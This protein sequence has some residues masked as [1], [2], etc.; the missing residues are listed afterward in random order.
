MLVPLLN[1]YGRPFIG[2]IASC[3]YLLLTLNEKFLYYILC[4]YVLILG[5]H[6]N[7]MF[8]TPL[9]YT[10]VCFWFFSPDDEMTGHSSLVLHVDSSHLQGIYICLCVCACVRACVHVCMHVCTE[11]CMCVYM[12]VYM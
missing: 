6:T 11:V 3:K 7:V 10:V 5:C 8:P 4:T 9:Y 12:H 1:E 2:K